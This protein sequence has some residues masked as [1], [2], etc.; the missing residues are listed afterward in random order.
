MGGLGGLGEPGRAA[1]RWRCLGQG[2]YGRHS[3]AGPVLGMSAAG[4]QLG[5]FGMDGGSGRQPGLPT[6]QRT[7]PVFVPCVQRGSWLTV[8]ARV[9][10]GQEQDSCS[11]A[12]CR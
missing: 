10:W 12:V 11:F 5:P 9:C 2:P 1:Q 4:L 6:A 3:S 7:W 8:G